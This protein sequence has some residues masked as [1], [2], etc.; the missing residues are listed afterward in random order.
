MGVRLTWDGGSSSSIQSRSN[1]R[2]RT[3]GG[4]TAQALEAYQ[5]FK[6]R[7]DGFSLNIDKPLS[8]NH[9]QF[10]DIL[11][12]GENYLQTK[13]GGEPCSGLIRIH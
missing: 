6:W 11:D 2:P 1:S 12:I 9:P 7:E 13:N 5:E 8:G 10:D 3:K 4:V